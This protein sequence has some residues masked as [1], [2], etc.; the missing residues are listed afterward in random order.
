MGREPVINAFAY[1]RE[2]CIPYRA[3]T[4]LEVYQMTLLAIRK[5]DPVVVWSASTS[6]GRE[7]LG[8]SPLS[9]R[10]GKSSPSDLPPQSIVFCPGCA[11]IGCSIC[12]ES[13]ITSVAIAKKYRAETKKGGG[14]A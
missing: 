7:I 8:Q 5:S 13:G 4:R 12:N 1:S 2:G 10:S 6:R 3:R 9:L 11:G 14:T